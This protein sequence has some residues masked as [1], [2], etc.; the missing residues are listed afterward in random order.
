MRN[1]GEVQI[2]PLLYD[3]HSHQWLYYIPECHGEYYA[4]SVETWLHKQT[5]NSWGAKVQPIWLSWWKIDC[6]VK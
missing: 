3:L 5:K 6:C 1:E 2:Q 4:D